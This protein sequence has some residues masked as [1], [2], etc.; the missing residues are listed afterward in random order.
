MSVFPALKCSYMLGL[1]AS[2][3]RP[4]HFMKRPVEGG[5]HVYLLLPSCYKNTHSII[6]YNA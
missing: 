1:L 6:I 3:S 2:F 5:L 4:L